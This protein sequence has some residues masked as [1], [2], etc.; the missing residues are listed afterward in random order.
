M[1]SLEERAW[2]FAMNAHASIQQ[3]RKYTGLPYITHPG[4]VVTILRT[5]EHVTESMLC[6]AW[7]HDTVEDV[8]G[9]TFAAIESELGPEVAHLVREVTC[10]SAQ[11]NGNR[12]MRKAL[13][14]AHYAKASA[15]GQTIKLADM[16]SNISTL[17]DLDPAFAQVYLKEAAQLLDVL[18]L[19]DP[20]LIAQAKA[21]L[22][23]GFR[24]IEH[25]ATC[26]T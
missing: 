5:L 6:V 22:L 8:P 3:K 26:S 4:E 15:H 12:K 2:L 11:S 7:L 13:D 21:C 16:I 23:R 19:A 14:R 25:G 10:V 24:T 9:V 17:P 20:A 18:V 1:S